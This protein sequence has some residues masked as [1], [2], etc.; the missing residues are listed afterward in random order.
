MVMRPSGGGPSWVWP[1]SLEPFNT[2]LSS[3]SRT[4]FFTLFDPWPFD[5]SPFLGRIR[6]FLHQWTLGRWITM[7]FW[8][9]LGKLVRRQHRYDASYNTMKLAPWYSTYWMGNSLGVHN[10]ETSW[11]DL[12]R[13]GNINVHI[14]NVESLSETTVK[15]NNGDVNKVEALVCCT[16]W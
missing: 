4:R 10:Y 8:N 2:S 9:M 13:K 1:L 7:Q 3:L 15:L 6:Q 11:F 5:N 16:G 14:A 12:G